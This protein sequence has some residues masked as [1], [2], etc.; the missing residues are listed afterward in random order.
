MLAWEL[1]CP[2]SPLLE[3]CCTS[4]ASSF[5]LVRTSLSAAGVPPPPVALGLLVVTLGV[6]CVFSPSSISTFPVSQLHALCDCLSRSFS[7]SKYAIPSLPPV[8]VRCDQL[9]PIAL[10]RHCCEWLRPWSR[11]RPVS[12]RSELTVCRSL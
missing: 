9:H 2:S 3:G 6:N 10:F 8:G 4:T 12:H 11:Q 7:S 5:M 1:E